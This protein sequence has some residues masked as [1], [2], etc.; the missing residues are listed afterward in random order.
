MAGVAVEADFGAGIAEGS[1]TVE[2]DGAGRACVACEASGALGTDQ[3]VSAR[4]AVDAYGS[5]A[6]R[7][8][9]REIEVP[10]DAGGAVGR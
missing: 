8:D 10:R 6:R 7:T 4:V 3:S 5:G 9:A 1:Q 2:A